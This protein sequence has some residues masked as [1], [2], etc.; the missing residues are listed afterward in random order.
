MKKSNINLKNEEEIAE[1]ESSD[2]FNASDSK[3]VLPAEEQAIEEPKSTGA[4]SVCFEWLQAIITALVIVVIVLTFFVRI[5]DVDGSSM[6]N[7]LQHGDKLLVTNFLYE[8]ENNDIVIISHGQE[9]SKPIVKR[10]IAK[11]GQRVKIDYENDIVTVDGVVLNE[12]YIREKDMQKKIDCVYNDVVVPE[13]ML[14]VMGDNR[15]GS[16]DSRSVE[17]GL[18][19]ENDVIGK[20]QC[21]WFPFNRGSYLY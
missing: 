7:T 6:T 14:F 20:A 5:V 8:V 3:Q 21:I 2:V 17:V 4:A 12:P 1:T 18:I 16:L 15:N 9:Y 19:N 11:A 10:V 13:G